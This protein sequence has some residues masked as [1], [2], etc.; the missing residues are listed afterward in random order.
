MRPVSVT[1]NSATASQT[2]PLDYISGATS[3]A[4]N[5]TGTLTYSVQVTND[6]VFDPTVTPQWSD[7]TGM[8]GKTASSNTAFSGAYRA[9]RLNV[10]AYTSGSATLTVVQSPE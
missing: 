1:V 6:N 4:V 3:F 5:M 10:T 8:S 2:I 7:Y 9:A